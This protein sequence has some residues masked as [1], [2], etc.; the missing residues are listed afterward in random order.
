MRKIILN[1][2]FFGVISSCIIGRVRPARHCLT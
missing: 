2:G 1:K